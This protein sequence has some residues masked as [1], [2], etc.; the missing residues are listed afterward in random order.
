MSNRNSLSPIIWG[1]K[2]WF[3]LESMAIG[4][5]EEPTN[6]EQ[7][8][9]KNLLLSLK[10]LLPCGGCRAN[11][12]NFIENKNM[13]DAVRDRHTLLNFLIDVHNDVRIKNGQ[14]PRAIGDI[15][16]YYQNAYLQNKPIDNSPSMSLN[17]EFFDNK[18]QEKLIENE[19]KMM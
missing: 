10:Y 3:F 16:I 11:Y 7:T 6:D 9:A 14:A 5:P 12:S 8:A 17:S 2:T 13:D 19:I 18:S 15:F 1:P 4:Y